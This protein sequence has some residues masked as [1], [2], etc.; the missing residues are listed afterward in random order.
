MSSNFP[1]GANFSATLDVAIAQ[2]NPNIILAARVISQPVSR[3]LYKTTNGGTT[4]TDI[5]SAAF[6][7][8]T[9]T[10][11]KIHPTQPNKIWVSFTAGYSATNANQARKLFYSEDGGTT[12]RNMTAGLP[13]VPIW[14]IAIQENSPIDAVYVGTGV[15]V[16]Y[17][18]VSKNQ[19]AEF[20]GGMP[21]GVVVTDLKIHA[22]SGKIFAGTYGRGIWSANLYDRPYEVNPQAL[23]ASRAGL[24]N[25]YPN[26][27]GNVVR[28]DWEAKNI[29]E[30]T[31][32]I[33]DLLGKTL[34]SQPEF[35][36]KAT[37]DMTAFPAGIYTVQ[38]KTGKEVVTKKF[39]KAN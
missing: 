28:I 13:N 27:V 15:G 39:F 34:F 10:D 19:F 38:L 26:P 33:T 1:Q 22:A 20:Q 17:K 4:W 8:A 18:D 21:R 25:V 12:W 7:A 37:F 14:S 6:P 24:L 9:I 2:S 3:A 11:I 30:Q 5:W 16:F 32:E 23:S 31:L 35:T 36:G 29:D